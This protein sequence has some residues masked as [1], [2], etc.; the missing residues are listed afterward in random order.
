[1]DRYLLGFVAWVQSAGAAGMLAFALAYVLATVL[2]LPGS[3]LTLGAGFVYGVGI[4]SAL[5]W[6]AANVGAALA[7]LLG[8]TLAREWI[9]ARV[10]RNPR[11]AA[12]DRA[13]AQQ[14][15][16]IV[17]L[18]RLSPVFPF[19][20]LNYAFGLTRVRFRDYV[21][22]SLVGMIPGTIMYVYLG[23]LVTSVTELAA[24][25]PS[26][27]AAQQV[28]YFAGLAVT[29]AVTVYVT[30]VARGA[31]GEVTGEVARPGPAPVA[32]P[33]VPSRA[34]VLPDDEHNRVLLS[35]VHPSGRPNP[36]PRGRYNLV[37]VGAG[38]AGL[39][40]AA[41]A[42]GLG[43]RVALVEHHLMGGDCLNVG[44]VPSKALISAARVAALTRAA[45]DFGVH[46]AAVEVDFPKVM[47][48]MRRLRARL[49]PTDSVAR[50]EQLGVDVYL[51]TGRFIGPTTLE[52]DGRM[53]EF[54]R[55]VIAT[56][57]RAAAPD[58]PGLEAVGYLTNETLFWLTELP[59]RLAVIGAGPIGCEMAQTFRRFGSEVTLF[60]M[61]AQILPR[62]DVEAA[63]IV[64]R[65]MRADGVQ[66]V[67]GAR[68]ARAERRGADIVVH[69]DADG[70]ARSVACDRILVGVGRAPNV[71]GLDLEAAG[72]TYDAHGVRVN[73]Y[74]QTTNPRIYA[75]GDIASRFKFTHTADFLARIVLQNALFL[76]RKKASAL[77]VPWCTYT[78]P[79][80]A[81]VGLSER[82][83]AARGIAVATLTVPLHEVD[84]AVLDGA[85]E[86]FLRVHLK[87]G[88]DRLLGA[89]LVA[90]H[91]GEMI[92]EITLAM[93]AGRGLGTLAA[94]IHPYPTQAEVI[95]KAGDAYN[96]T[97]LTPTVKK[98]F[99]WWLARRR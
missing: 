69:Y 96:R 6:V 32:R 83:A 61:G 27:G 57:A 81:H 60:E 93:V 23:S 28:F 53:L 4:G 44:C 71:E 29:V 68:V 45:A 13:V 70:A 73:D 3:I 99:A 64:Q 17:L 62:E 39:V 59:R 7:F 19:N 14:G 85:D 88:T 47:E 80:L 74:L 87:K 43:A 22:G 38:T 48:R 84:R 78:S 24:G 65:R 30:R 67:F 66:L 33:E 42:A 79:E 2:F 75:A 10:A 8:R 98:L 63:A 25:R 54:S 51:G 95:R 50:F 20:V 40:S 9:A 86:G 31:L 26:G 37:V 94:T 89:T 55:A 46:T 76:G 91:A 58:I 21:L 41:G 49:A 35:Q 82:E 56:G 1:M 77:H 16:R 15:L 11:F 97:R 18:T 92:S 36:T 72:V 90:E 5:V 12:I 52:V 34:L